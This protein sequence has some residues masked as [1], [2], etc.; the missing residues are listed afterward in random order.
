[1]FTAMA[2]L[3]FQKAFDC[4]PHSAILNKLIK[5]NFPHYLIMLIKSYLSHRTLQTSYNGCLSEPKRIEASV[6]QGSILG[7]TLYIIYTADFPT[8]EDPNFTIGTYADDTA[9]IQRSFRPDVALDKLQDKLDDVETWCEQWKAKIN[10]SKSQVIIFKRKK[11]NLTTNKYLEVF[12]EKLE[13]TTTVKYLGITFNE[14]LTWGDHVQNNLNKANG[15]MQRLNPLIGYKS[16]LDISTKRRIYLAI[17]R[18]L[19]TYAS[20]AWATVTD[21]WLQKLHTFQN[22][23]VKQIAKAPWYVRR[24]NLHKNLNIPE[25]R[26]FL[27]KLNRKFCQRNSKNNSALTEMIY[28]CMTARTNTNRPFA[29]ILDMNPDLKQEILRSLQPDPGGTVL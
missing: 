25:I 27:N 11:K 23:A 5:R 17:I 6:S 9:L 3:D 13:R 19:L 2:L 22:K 28:N 16:N 18:P 14:K 8:W 1:M 15:M 10:G 20:P 26:T 24:R 29:K 21:S 7:P 4:T 12:Q